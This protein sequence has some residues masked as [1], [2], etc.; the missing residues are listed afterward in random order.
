MTTA[1][2]YPTTVRNFGS[3]VVDFTDTIIA[4]HVN[5]LRA[6]V[7]AIETTLGTL[8]LTSSGWVGS[9]DQTTTTWNTVRDR[10]ANIEYG[11]NTAYAAKVPT[12]GTTG[13][14]LV[15]SSN[16]DYAM[17]WTTGNFLPSQ[18]THSGQ[19]LTTNGTT[20]SWAAINQYTAPTLGSTSIGSGATVTTVS[21]LTENN[22]TL[23]GTLTAGSSTGTSGY[24]LQT[25]GT[26]VQWAS[27][28]AS[29]TAP[30]IGSTSIPSG[31]T[32]TTIAGLTLTNP[33][34]N[35]FALG[36]STTVT[37]GGTTTL[38]VSSNNQQIFT[39]TSTQT[40]VLPV[41]STMVVGQRF[42]I[43][44]NSTGT[45]TVNSSGGNL[46]ISVPGGYSVKVTNILTSGTTAASWDAEYVGFNNIPAS[47]GE[48]FNPLLLIGA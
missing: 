25:T 38:T 3:D 20:A 10:I 28:P 18:S 41:A 6:E 33:A 36:Y 23:T 26:G 9:F 16:S 34:I 29:Y 5:Y 13:Q 22:L 15:K 7:A 8:P 39:G 19:F 30:T 45:V 14:V 2:T 44:N 47:S 31:A 17:T 27:V 32:V 48:T 1:A 11:L 40:V 4:I 46:V 21:G 24:F 35:N 42:L 12:G 43:E 37:A